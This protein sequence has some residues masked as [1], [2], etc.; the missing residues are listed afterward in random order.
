MALAMIYPTPAK[1]KR[2][3]SGY[4]DSEEQIS[5]SLLSACR[6]VLKHSR[7]LAGE[8]TGLQVWP[9]NLNPSSGRRHM[10]AGQR[11]MATAMLYPEK[12]KWSKQMRET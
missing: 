9:P 8:V 3:G 1:V 10:T 7:A 6:A 4:S 5:A 12:S 11:A 2:K